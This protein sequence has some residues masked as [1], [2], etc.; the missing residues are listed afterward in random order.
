MNRSPSTNG[1][2]GRDDRGRF[3]I[4]N[5]G[6]PGN[7]H[8]SRVAQLRSILFDAV[9]ADD[10]TQIASKLAEQAKEGDPRACQLLLSY[11]LG[12]PAQGVYQAE[13]PTGDPAQTPEEVVR[14]LILADLEDR[15][16][17]GLTRYIEPVKR[18]LRESDPND[19]GEADA[20]T[21]ADEVN[22][23]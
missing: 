15:V 16:P 3:T 10:L 9:T 6:G 5:A 7:P 21:G 11:L 1:S 18:S 20:G 23:T 22:L 17:P 12:K 19:D 4:G 13:G 14:V 2:N 8:A